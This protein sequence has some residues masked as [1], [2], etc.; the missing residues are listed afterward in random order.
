M[1]KKESMKEQES[2]DHSASAKA[3]SLPVSTKHCIVIGDNIRY[4]S[5]SEAKDILENVSSL[6][7]AIPFRRFN[8]DMGHK[9][10]IAS[11]RYPQKAAKEIIKLIKSVEANAQVKGLDVE[12]LK[13]SK[14]IS[15][16]ASAPMTG[17]RHRR[18]TKRTHV[19][20][21]VKEFSVKKKV[22]SEK[23]KTKIKSEKPAEKPVKEVKK[24]LKAKPEVKEESKVDVKVEKSVEKK[25]VTE[26]KEGAQ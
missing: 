23:N 2:K 24:E 3:K 4:K 19:E 10:G 25:E 14:V 15:N 20:I 7:K 9:A 18:G 21:E 5:T 26:V 11:G 22:K 13:I 17:G 12:N 1:A 8:R 16:K 6:K